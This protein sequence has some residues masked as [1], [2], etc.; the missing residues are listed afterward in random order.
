MI[1]S[2]IQQQI[3]TDKELFERELTLEQAYQKLYKELEHLKSENERLTKLLEEY[4]TKKNVML[5]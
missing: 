5:Y 4:R 3:P 1:I 2:T